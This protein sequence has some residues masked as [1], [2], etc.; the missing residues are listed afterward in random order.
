V[1]P[2]VRDIHGKSALGFSDTMASRRL[3]AAYGVRSSSVRIVCRYRRFADTACYD[4]KSREES[5]GNVHSGGQRW[6]AE[7]DGLVCARVHMHRGVNPLPP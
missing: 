1:E 2:G 4:E 5:I 6:H 7:H 3:R